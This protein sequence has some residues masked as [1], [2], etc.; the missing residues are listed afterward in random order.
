MVSKEIIQRI[1]ESKELHLAPNGKEYFGISLMAIKSI[2]QEETSVK[3]KKSLPW[4][5][6]LFLYVITAILVRL[7]G[8][9]R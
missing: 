1:E 8:R 6:V 4:R 2:A 7:A 9:D 5:K 3:E